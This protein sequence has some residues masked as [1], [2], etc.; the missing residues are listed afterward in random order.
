[1]R[2]SEVTSARLVYQHG[3]KILASAYISIK[4]LSLAWYVQ[5]QQGANSALTKH[6]SVAAAQTNDKSALGI[7]YLNHHITI[8]TNLT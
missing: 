6:G 5:E 7:I 1:M 4:R 3:I 2:S 8:I